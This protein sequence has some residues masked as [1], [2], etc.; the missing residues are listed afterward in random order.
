MKIYYVRKDRRLV[1]VG[2]KASPDFWDSHWETE[3]LKESIERGK[4]NRFVLKTLR[5][6]IPD[7]KGRILEGGCGRG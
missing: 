6:Y 2:E 5:K 4:D 7:K 1:Y 3:N